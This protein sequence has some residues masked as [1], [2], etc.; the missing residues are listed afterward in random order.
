MSPACKV[1]WKA[2]K[3]LSPAKWKKHILGHLHMETKGLSKTGAGG[4]EINITVPC[5]TRL[6]R[7]LTGVT[8]SE[9]PAAGENTA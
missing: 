4:K 3:S 8:I 7:V 9:K 6:S 5:A 1:P 2:D